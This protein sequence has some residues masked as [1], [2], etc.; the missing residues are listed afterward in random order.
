MRARNQRIANLV[1][2]G[3]A[4][5]GATTAV[6]DNTTWGSPGDV[7]TVFLAG[8]GTRIVVGALTGRGAG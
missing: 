5:L 7:M 2:A 4:A 1:I 8:V 3:L 6:A